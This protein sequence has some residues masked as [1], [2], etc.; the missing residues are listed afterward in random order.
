[1]EQKFD[2]LQSLKGVAEEVYSPGIPSLESL[3][4]V[5]CG[6]DDGGIWWGC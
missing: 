1:M 3:L 2:G 5:A 6:L 4:H